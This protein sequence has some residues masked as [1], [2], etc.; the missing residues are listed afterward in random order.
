MI[1]SPG[2]AQT[3]PDVDGDGV[4]DAE[5][6]CLTVPNADQRDV[7][8]DGLGDACDLTPSDDEEVSVGDADSGSAMGCEAPQSALACTPR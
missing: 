1:A 3:F 8:G 4:A 2:L 5:D 6:N 7:D